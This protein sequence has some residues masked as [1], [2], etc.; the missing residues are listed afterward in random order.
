MSLRDDVEV[1]A[2]DVAH[3]QP[4]TEWMGWFRRLCTKPAATQGSRSEL[5]G[6]DAGRLCPAYI[7]DALRRT[8]FK[9][10]TQEKVVWIDHRKK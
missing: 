1:Q 4:Q 2:G 7:E 5:V 9:D 3:L 6:R 10:V 8:F